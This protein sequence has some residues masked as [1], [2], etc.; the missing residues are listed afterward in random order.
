MQIGELFSQTRA[1]VTNN[2]KLTEETPA[3]VES[4]PSLPFEINPTKRL[5]EFD[6]KR[7]KTGSFF[8]GLPLLN[9][10]P[11]NGIGYGVRVFYFQ[12][13][14]KKDPFFEYTP[15]RYRVFAQ[16]F[17]TTRDAQNHLASFDAPY[18]LDTQWRLRADLIY[19]RNPN[20]LFFGVGEETLKPLAYR[21]NNDSTR[22][23]IQNGSFADYMD[24]LSYKR[25]GNA[26]QAPFVTDTKYN[27]Y[28]ME[29]PNLNFST[30]RSFFGGL[31]RL[32]GG[33]R[34]SRQIIRTFDGRTEVAKDPLFGDRLLPDLLNTVPNSTTLLTEESQAGRIRGIQGGFVNTLRAGIV[35]DT[36]DFEPDPN[37]GIF[38]EYTHERAVKQLGSDYQFNRNTASARFF[39]S[40]F[41]R[42]FQ[43]L[44]IAGRATF[45]QTNGEAPFY[46]YRNI[47]GTESNQVGLG[48][49]TTLRGFKPE[50]FIG[51][52]MAFGNLE[53]R[54]KFA[55]VA[56]K[57]STFDFQLV[58]FVDFGR[59]WDHYSRANFKDYK[60]SYG[61][62]FRIPWNQSTIIY[63]DY[64][65]SREDRQL[66]VN[67]QHIF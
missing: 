26:G 44:V 52:A 10:D 33:A 27:R 28:D 48:G 54:W 29:N 41:P 13:K 63:F 47:W 51:P 24:A 21:E 56:T 55:S 42:T 8:T 18:F 46:E 30:E 15:Y 39:Y 19:E 4:E 32:V 16:Y 25:P 2:K 60:Y 34:L 53:L 6:I 49:R 23:L 22:P 58:P 65:I 64:A 37:R 3:E 20:F 17:R 67:F 36:R 59:V 1:P 61:L 11:N 38:M 35:Y 14:D 9:S 66:F 31:M 50:R 45:T 40:P 62:G 43:K 57:T 12:N 5:T 7:K